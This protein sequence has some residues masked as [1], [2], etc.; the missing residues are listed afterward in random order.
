MVFI[1]PFPLGA[2][3]FLLANLPGMVYLVLRRKG[4]LSP[5]DVVE[6][7]SALPQAQSELILVL[8]RAIALATRAHPDEWEGQ[9]VEIRDVLSRF[10]CES[11]SISPELLGP[12]HRLDR[13]TKE[14]VMNSHALRLVRDTMD[15]LTQAG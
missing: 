1:G 15:Q 3:V 13:S 11:F 9:A 12:L 4:D 2:A 7:Q 14:H 10:V 5:T 8:D 6:L